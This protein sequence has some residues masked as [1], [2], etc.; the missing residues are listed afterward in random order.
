MDTPTDARAY[1][2]PMGGATTPAYGPPPIAPAPAPSAVPAW[3]QDAHSNRV[4]G[5][6]GRRPS[7]PWRRALVVA[8]IALLVLVG[9]GAGA[10]ALAIRPSIHGQVDNNLRTALANTISQIPPTV[11]PNEY[12]I[13]AATINGHI[14]QDIP[15]ASGV[16]SAEVH[17]QNDD[18]VLRYTYQGNSGTVTT[19]LVPVNGRLVAQ[20]TSVTGVLGWVESGDEV[21]AALNAELIGIP[22]GYHITSIRTDND[23]LIVRVNE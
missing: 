4:A 21:Q 5:E 3:P 20:N 19:Q 7:S 6:G 12:A 22:S 17:F 2:A 16:S 15:A 18:V 11:P 9:L 10:W 23:T 13:S 8:L 1:E 14:T